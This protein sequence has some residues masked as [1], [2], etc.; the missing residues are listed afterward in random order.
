MS[1]GG[2]GREEAACGGKQRQ[3]SSDLL[4]AR[5]QHALEVHV[6]R[7]AAEHEQQRRVGPRPPVHG[8]RHGHAGV[9]LVQRR[10]ESAHGIRDERD[11]DPEADHQHAELRDVSDGDGPQAARRRVRH[12][13][14][15]REHDRPGVVEIEHD[16]ERRAER[17]E[18]RRRPEQLAGDGRQIQSR[19][20]ALAETAVKGVEERGEAVAPHQR[21]E[22]QPADR[23][24]QGIGPRRLHVQQPR[25]VRLLHGAVDVAAVDPR[26]RHREHAD[27]QP[28]PASGEHEVAEAVA[29]HAPGRP[30]ADEEGREI[31]GAHRREASPVGRSSAAGDGDGDDG[32][33]DRDDECSVAGRHP[34]RDDTT[35]PRPCK[36]R[37]PAPSATVIPRAATPCPAARRR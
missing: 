23:Q 2:Q 30:Q 1:A 37:L 6:P 9:V 15:R 36:V 25:R 22:P 4:V 33:E 34:A 11:D 3:S 16:A 8:R 28:Q 7:D 17:G 14:R 31:E 12:D 20:R 26:G 32:Q 21:R 27:A 13:D 35:S 10:A 19:R 5:R 18:N 29:S 24:A